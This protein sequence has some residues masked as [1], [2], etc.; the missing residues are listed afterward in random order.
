[1]RSKYEP[2]A[3]FISCVLLVRLFFIS[4][5]TGY[6]GFFTLLVVFK[7]VYF[8]GV[9][10]TIPKRG[11]FLRQIYLMV[12]EKLQEIYDLLYGRFGAQGWW[13]SDGRLE[14][15]IGAILTQN[16]N[17]GNVEK[18]MANLRSAG[19]LSLEK[20]RSISPAELGELIRPAGY[21]NIKAGRLKNFVE[22]LFENYD[23]E[24]SVME[25]IGTE[26]LRE[27]LLGVKGIGF[28]TADSILLYAFGREVFVV[29]AYTARVAARHGLIEAGCGYEELRELFESNLPTN[30]EMFNEY[31]ALFVRVGKEYCRRTARC[32]GCPLEKLPHNVEAED[33]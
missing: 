15:I 9:E 24:L 12:S 2:G 29:D 22:W 10:N 31:H 27:E 26:S 16:T 20:L 30:T 7:R 25:S 4:S 13:P 11:C 23:G 6:R 17:W 14:I 8:K 28:E 33:F 1:V 3:K 32:A 21:Y 18:A 5:S 19:A